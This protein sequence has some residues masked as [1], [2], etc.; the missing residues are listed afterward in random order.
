MLFGRAE[1]SALQ[2]GTRKSIAVLG[3]VANHDRGRGG[4]FF[5]R[6]CSARLVKKTAGRY[7]LKCR[8]II[9]RSHRQMDHG[10]LD[11]D[12]RRGRCNGLPTACTIRI[13]AIAGGWTTGRISRCVANGYRQTDG[14]GFS[15]RPAADE[16]SWLR[17]EMRKSSGKRSSTVKV[18]LFLSLRC[19]AVA[20][21]VL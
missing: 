6:S 5:G 10:L 3:A 16:H 21:A 1:A 17:T 2:R 20:Q 4:C 8:T 12:R 19:I 7:P 13:R 18:L 14:R 11:I 9:P 15:T